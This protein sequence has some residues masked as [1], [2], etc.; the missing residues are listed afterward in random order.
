MA[1]PIINYAPVA[2]QN[3]ALGRT[4]YVPTIVDRGQT[5]PLETVIERAIDR[6]LIVGIKPTAATSIAQ[7]LGKQ[8]YAEFSN[9][10]GIKFG[11]YFYGRLYLG[12][13]CGADGKLSPKNEINVRLMPGKGYRVKYG[14]FTYQNVESALVPTLDFVISDTAGAVRNKPVIDATLFVNGTK[15][16]GEGTTTTIEFWAVDSTGEITG[17][18]PAYTY[19][20]FTVAG[21][22][23]IAFD[24]GSTIEAANYVAKVVRTAST[25]TRTE[26]VPLEVEVVVA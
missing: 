2:M 3:R 13:T 18:E 25:G 24:L 5:V 15:L 4:I 23:L 22:S 21:E 17:D 8:M 20:T 6:G 12:G 26:S 9:G 7:G 14:D 11:D 16:V 10:R 1:K 19:D